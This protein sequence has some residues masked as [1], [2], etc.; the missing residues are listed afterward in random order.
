VVTAR[1]QVEHAG[2]QVGVPSDVRPGGDA[3]LIATLTARPSCGRIQ[4]I[5]FGEP[6]TPFANARVSITDSGGPVDQTH[7]FV[8]TPAGGTTAVSFSI[9]RVIPS[10]G[11]TVSPIRLYDDCGEWRTL[12][13]GDPDAFR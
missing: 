8:Y 9:H 10:G 5:Q 13:G 2:V 12:V 4:R 7:G 6:G 1:F 3:G 11:A